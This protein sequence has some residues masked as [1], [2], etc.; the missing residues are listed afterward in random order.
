MRSIV[1][2]AAICVALATVWS[3]SAQ[4]VGL[5][6]VGKE[7]CDCSPLVARGIVPDP[8]NKLTEALLF[9]QFAEVLDRIALEIKGMVDQIGKPPV[10]ETAAVAPETETAKEKPTIEEKP[11][12]KEK[13]I[14]EKKPAKKIK[15]A[16]LQAS[17]QKAKKKKPVKMPSRVM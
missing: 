1:I 14:I 2:A 12:K 8:L 13:T 6:V 10:A 4:A 16:S 17:K 5:Y 9:P 3:G 7:D 15:K 11:V